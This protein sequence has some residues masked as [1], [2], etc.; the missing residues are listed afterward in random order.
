VW[1]IWLVGLLAGLAIY[2]LHPKV[3]SIGFVLIAGIFSWCA[4]SL[5][6]VLRAAYRFIRQ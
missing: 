5:L 6:L 3:D 1:T 2:G 4:Y